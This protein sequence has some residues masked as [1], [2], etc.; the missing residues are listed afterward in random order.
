MLPLVCSPW[1]QASFTL[2]C[3]VA[4]ICQAGFK[5]YK[6]YLEGFAILCEKNVSYIG[7]VKFI[8][9]LPQPLF[10]ASPK[11]PRTLLQQTREITGNTV[12]RIYTVVPVFLNIL[13]NANKQIV[14]H[15]NDNFLLIYDFHPA[16]FPATISR[17]P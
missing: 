1:F 8:E 10:I 17:A 9:V 7:N 15:T 3:T 2:C 4:K 12:C 6:I 16:A 13:S 11:L 5:L 14:T